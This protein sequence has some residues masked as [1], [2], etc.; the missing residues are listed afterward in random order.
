[1]GL[2]CIFGVVCNGVVGLVV[3]LNGVTFSLTTSQEDCKK[4]GGAACIGCCMG[5]LVWACPD[6]ERVTMQHS[7]DAVLRNTRALG[8]CAWE[9]REVV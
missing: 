5:C 8:T 6:P 3:C 9:R 1:M 7:N 4:V 2:A